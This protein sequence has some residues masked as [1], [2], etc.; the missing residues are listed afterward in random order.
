M[1]VTRDASKDNKYT[2][3]FLN[4]KTLSPMDS[5]YEK[6]SLSSDEKINWQNCLGVIPE[7][8][9]ADCLILQA[10]IA[11]KL[12]SKI[13]FILDAAMVNE[14]QKKA[15]SGLIANAIYG[16]ISR[17]RDTFELATRIAK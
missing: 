6:I 13:D 3:Y 16:E 11:Q 12:T 8:G 9:G 15:T 5:P 17:C 10:N 1:S 7:G 14:K 4:D 2:L